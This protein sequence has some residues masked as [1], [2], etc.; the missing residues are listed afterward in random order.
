MGYLV[1]LAANEWANP[2]IYSE[3]PPTVWLIYVITKHAGV[4]IHNAKTQQL[5]HGDRVRIFSGM[6]IPLG[7]EPTPCKLVCPQKKDTEI[8]WVKGDKLIIRL[9]WVKGW[10]MIHHCVF[11]FLRWPHL[12]TSGLLCLEGFE[13]KKMTLLN[14]FANHGWGGSQYDIHHS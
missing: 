6:G 10:W 9:S 14:H 11:F 8:S 13:T 2:S 12:S 7:R 5:F 4:P 1:Q 3:R